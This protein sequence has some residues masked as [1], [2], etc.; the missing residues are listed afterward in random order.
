LLTIYFVHAHKERWV[1]QATSAPILFIATTI[2]ISTHSLFCG[3]T[4]GEIGQTNNINNHHDH[5][6]DNIKIYLLAILWMHTRR[7]RPNKQ[8]QHPSYSL[9][10]TT[11]M[12]TYGLFCACTQREID[13]TNN[14]S[15]HHIPLQQ[16][17]H[18]LLTDYFVDAH[19]ER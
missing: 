11:S 15:T 13:Q 17:Y 8:H 10:T 18:Y 4:Q 2:S 7:D 16:Q 12:S 9:S 19:K 3:C 1:K 5:C 14:I 6:N